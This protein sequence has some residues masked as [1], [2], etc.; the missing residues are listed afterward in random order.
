M[1]ERPDFTED[2]IE[3]IARRVADLDT[4]Q[5][6]LRVLEV[7]RG[8]AAGRVKAVDIPEKVR[9]DVI[10][11]LARVLLMEALVESIAQDNT[12][13]AGRVHV[14][15]NALLALKGLLAERMTTDMIR[16]VAN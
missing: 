6:M 8:L 3:T 15:L 14:S 13:P 12:T 16:G 7:V 9:D 4:R 5:E 2:E 10:P 11:A 1:Q